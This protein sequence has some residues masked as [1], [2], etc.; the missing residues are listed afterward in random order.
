MKTVKESLLFLRHLGC[1]VVDLSNVNGEAEAL[2]AQLNAEGLVDGIV[3]PDCD[4]FLFGARCVYKDFSIGKEKSNGHATTRYTSDQI[5]ENL[6]FERNKMIAFATLTGSDYAEGGVPNLGGKTAK[7]ILDFYSNGE[8]L[9]VLRGWLQ[10][11]PTPTINHDDADDYSTLSEKELRV[12]AEENGLKWTGKSKIV[13]VLQ[14]IRERLKSCETPLEE[15]SQAIL[16]KKEASF[17]DKWKSRFLV[18][19]AQL[20]ER[21]NGPMPETALSVF[22]KI[23]AAYKHPNISGNPLASLISRFKGDGKEI[24]DVWPRVEVSLFPNRH[25]KRCMKM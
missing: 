15:R 12:C 1:L 4:A 22:D 9:D 25:I 23:V 20:A 19:Y 17:L 2:C 18:H 8:C 7:K 5:R 13:K 10:G 6:G 24:S 3:T 11:V 14:A 16:S 21:P